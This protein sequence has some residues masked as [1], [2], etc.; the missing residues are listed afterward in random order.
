MNILQKTA[1]LANGKKT[2]AAAT[3]MVVYAV[4][5]VILGHLEQEQAVQLILEALAIAGL[6]RA[7]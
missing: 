3:L 4:S 2:Y 7:L 5:G 1:N 6:R